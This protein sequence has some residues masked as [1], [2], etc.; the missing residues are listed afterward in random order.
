MQKGVHSTNWNYGILLSG[1]SIQD[2]FYALYPTFI[3]VTFSVVKYPWSYFYQVLEKKISFKD[4]LHLCQLYQAHASIEMYQR[5]LFSIGTIFFTFFKK[6]SLIF[7]KTG[8]NLKE[9]SEKIGIT[10]TPPTLTRLSYSPTLSL[11]DVG[12]FHRQITAHWNLV[13]GF[14]GRHYHQLERKGISTRKR[15]RKKRRRRRRKGRR[16][17]KMIDEGL[18]AFKRKEQYK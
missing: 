1:F 16:K 6:K 7:F 13:L 11:S 12:F 9:I 14:H 10:L 18:K 3:S 8:D 17:R 4:R 2:F 15:K 5:I